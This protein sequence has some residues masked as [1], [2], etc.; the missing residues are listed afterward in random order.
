ME[1]PEPDCPPCPRLAGDS[2]PFPFHAYKVNVVLRSAD[3]THPK[4][5]LEAVPKLP[6]L[7]DGLRQTIESVRERRGVRVEEHY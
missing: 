3:K 4:F 1:A 5:V 7:T 6:A 2:P